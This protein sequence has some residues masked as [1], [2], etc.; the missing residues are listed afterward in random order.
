MKKF[1]WLGVVLV[2][3]LVGVVS[4]FTVFQSFFDSGVAVNPCTDDLYRVS[5]HVP[6][7][8]FNV[9]VGV[10]VTS[11]S[12][13]GASGSRHDASYFVVARFVDGSSWTSGSFTAMRDKGSV[14]QSFMVPYSKV[15]S[16]FEVWGSG[17]SDPLNSPDCEVRAGGLDWVVRVIEC[18]EGY[19]LVD[20]QCVIEGVP[21]TSC[22]DGYIVSGLSCIIP[23]VV[24]TEC[25]AG[26]E[27]RGGACY[28]VGDTVITCPEGYS[29]ADGVCTIPGSVVVTCPEGYE[30]RDGA[31]YIGGTIVGGVPIMFWYILGGIIVLGIVGFIVVNKR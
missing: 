25:P 23:G 12:L 16:A 7:F 8:L 10:P 15:V 24:V 28:V 4:W 14:F 2:V 31:C 3:V 1:D 21:V 13:W 20:G 26:Y 5:A 22:P 27:L 6:V 30:L 9:S 19:S 17:P 18:P 29:L 11:V